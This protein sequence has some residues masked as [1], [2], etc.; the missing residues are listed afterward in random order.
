MTADAEF[1]R[2][3]SK[4]GQKNAEFRDLMDS[5]KYEINDQTRAGSYSTT[6]TLSDDKVQFADAVVE[7]FAQSDDPCQVTYDADESTLHISWE[8]PEE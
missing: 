4:Q 2:E 7:H 5:I 6:Y 1:L 3:K 8:Q